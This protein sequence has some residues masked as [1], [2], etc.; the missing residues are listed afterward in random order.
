[1]STLYP[2]LW[3]ESK[4]FVFAFDLFHDKAVAANTS[5]YPIFFKSNHISLK[6][7]RAKDWILL[8]MMHVL[9]FKT[10]PRAEWMRQAEGE[11]FNKQLEAV[12]GSEAARSAM[13]IGLRVEYPPG[14]GQMQRVLVVPQSSIVDHPEGCLLAHIKQSLC[15][16]CLT[17]A[18]ELTNARY[19][20][21]PREPQREARRVQ[22]FRSAEASWAAATQGSDERRTWAR[23]KA[24]REARLKAAGQKGRICAYLSLPPLAHGAAN[25]DSF[26]WLH[27]VSLGFGL[28][29]M[30][31]SLQYY[32]VLVAVAG[33]TRVAE[34]RRVDSWVVLFPASFRSV[35]G[36]S[37]SGGLSMLL[38]ADSD[39]LKVRR[40]VGTH[41]FSALRY[42]RAIVYTRFQRTRKG[43][44]INASLAALYAWI[45][46]A[47]RTE[48]S[49]VQLKE[50]RHMGRH[51]LMSLAPA[52]GAEAFAKKRKPHKITHLPEK[53]R[54]NGTHHN[55]A[56]AGG[57]AMMAPLKE[58][59]RLETNNRD[60]AEQIARAFEML[61]AVRIATRRKAMVDALVHYTAEMGNAPALQRLLDDAYGDPDAKDERGQTALAAA[62]AAAPFT[63]GHL[64]CVNLLLEAGASPSLHKRTDASPLMLAVR[65]GNL[66]AV[67]TL[68]DT[69]SGDERRREVR[70][71]WR[72]CNAVDLT[73]DDEM[74]Q[75]LTALPGERARAM[76]RD[77]WALQHK[78][79]QLIRRGR[80]DVRALLLPG[81]KPNGAFAQLTRKHPQL[82]ELADAFRIFRNDSVDLVRPN[83]LPRVGG[84]RL[85]L[86]RGVRVAPAL[87]HKTVAP[88]GDR[89]A[90]PFAP[91]TQRACPPS[92][93]RCS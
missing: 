85:S 59:L 34:L 78:A 42:F 54:H 14:S 77:P 39:P 3:A 44:A 83:S 51:W 90:A 49:E 46:A 4:A 81:S 61:D 28:D 82:C 2:N 18:T 50:L 41:I 75:L 58:L 79:V 89:R 10:K 65:Q 62:L 30:E 25:N 87:N 80:G 56:D 45:V 66:P 57:E 5:L 72:G 52:F 1:M 33:S 19:P 17:P 15:T 60:V 38:S 71:T 27:N 8:T 92:R 36:R 86:R 70:K 47:N 64:Q 11:L 7:A 55:H 13:S 48:Q 9:K 76:P 37:R 16:C 40:L 23:R 20:R 21:V 6:E 26:A 67:S 24:R 68:L 32:I 84:Q 35:Q 88:F 53:T 22:R 69:L 31:L 73:G 74:A 63:D 29:S 91:H 93:R 43:R 12:L